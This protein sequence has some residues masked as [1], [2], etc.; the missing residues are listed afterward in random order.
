MPCRCQNDT[1]TAPAAR[2]DNVLDS[3]LGATLSTGD[4]IGANAGDTTLRV[5]DL[6]QVPASGWVYAGDNIIR[7]TGRSASSGA[8]TLTGIPATGL[9]SIAVN[10][11]AGTPV[12]AAPHLTGVSGVLYDILPG[13]EVSVLTLSQDTTA[14]AALATLMGTSDGVMV[15]HIADGR[16]SLTEAQARGDATLA[17]SK[18]PII[19]V[20]FSSRDQSYRVGRNVDIDLTTPSVNGTFRIQRVTLSDMSVDGGAAEIFPLRQV[21]A[22]SRRYSF[23]SLL[24]ELR[25]SAA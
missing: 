3:S 19:T 5:L 6:S 25:G 7:Y 15:R 1:R 21:E 13:D 2:A 4:A 16:L 17:M 24:R 22:S 9:G 23:E 20:T 11:L 8:G 12:V 18:D 10:I 14:Q